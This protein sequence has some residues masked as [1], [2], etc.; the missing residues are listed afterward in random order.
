MTSGGSSWV[1]MFVA[2]PKGIRLV[3]QPGVHMKRE[4]GIL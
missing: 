1:Y 2:M 3:F 4:S